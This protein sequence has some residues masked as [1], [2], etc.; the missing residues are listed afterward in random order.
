[1]LYLRVEDDSKPGECEE[2]AY[3]QTE[4][5]REAYCSTGV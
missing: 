4:S 1:M 5:K 3:Q 2:P